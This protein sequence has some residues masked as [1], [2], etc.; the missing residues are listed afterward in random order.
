MKINVY[1][2]HDAK[3]EA[4]MQPF[5]ARTDE[6]AKRGFS[7]VVNGQGQI[8]DH[9]G[10]FTIF[11]IGEYNDADGSLVPVDKV[12]LGNALEFKTTE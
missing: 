4:Y 8:H 3:I 10:D 2:I 5:Y 9:P 1:A 6:E 12:S 11:K 7:G